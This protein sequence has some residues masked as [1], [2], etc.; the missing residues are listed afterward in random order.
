MPS[1]RAQRK[2][3]PPAEKPPRPRS[4]AFPYL[5]AV[6]AATLDPIVTIDSVGIIQSAS[7]SVQRVFG[8]T[9]AELIGRNI[10]I[11]MPEPHHSAHD[12][13][14]VK[15]H[16]T[17]RTEHLNRSRR[18][19]AVRKDGTLFPLE[20][21]VS[22][23]DIPGEAAP[24]FVGIIRD[25]SQRNGVGAAAERGRD[26]TVNLGES[27][28]TSGDSTRLYRL[29]A[30]QTA[31]L[32]SAHLRLRV[33]DRL[34]S[35]G[36]LAAGLGHD[37]NNV[38]LPVRAHLEA[39]GTLTVM[40]AVRDHIDAVH[41]SVTYLQ[42]LADGLHFLA[43]DTEGD[44]AEYSATDL[45]VWWSQVGPLLTKAIPKHV[46]VTVSMPANL[47]EVGV[48]AHGL[49]QA[50][51]N[52]FVNAGEAIPSPT[53]PRKGRSGVVSMRA[54][55][56]GGGT[57]VRLEVTD[58]GKG[59]SAETQ[60]RAFE[61]FYTSK[62]RGMGTGL[63]LPL[64]ARVV[65]R[66]G[67]TVEVASKLGE[68]TTVTVLIPIA[69]VRRPSTQ[70]PDDPRVV[71]TL[72]NQRAAA[73]IRHLFDVAGVRVAPGGDPAGADIWVLDPTKAALGGA[74]IWRMQ[75]PHG[76]LVLFGR[77]D[78]GSARGWKSLSPITIE[79][80]DDLDAIGAVLARAVVDNR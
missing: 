41:K 56:D 9:P 55:R 8:W 78:P 22:R 69:E 39:A 36:A 48:S 25:L 59:M 61:M 4:K 73:L 34:A 7:D 18:F 38:L 47:P 60:R 19:E 63:G 50:V 32:Q 49:T 5:E 21:S 35:I 58:N 29:L 77:A 72:T 52:L 15:Y 62:T 3:R 31:A 6:L 23:V 71:I 43:L 53:S 74:R 45:S 11:L 54:T 28:A 66:A 33:S 30:E 67:G 75:H 76:R 1:D 65:S 2:R 10:S 27:L 64:V 24:M 17:G 14:L 13:Y 79:G 37:M 57:H 68:G 51:L 16:Q 20:V 26:D 44:D 40:P 12:A 80:R 46:R 70:P 42:Q